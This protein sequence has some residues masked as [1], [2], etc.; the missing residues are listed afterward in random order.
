MT[1]A[2]RKTE[3]SRRGVMIGAAGFTFAVASGLRFAEPKR[4]P[5]PAAPPAAT[6]WP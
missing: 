6:M 5:P 4:P 1:I 2:I 3:I